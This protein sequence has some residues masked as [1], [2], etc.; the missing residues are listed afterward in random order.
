MADILILGGTRNLGHVTA[1]A[2][3]EAGHKV[4]VMN[5]GVTPDELPPDV[6]RLRGDRADSNQ[7]RRAIN[8]LDFDLVLDTTTYTG[9]DA[10]SAI[11]V[12]QGH[13]GRYV[14]VSTGQVYLV[15][16][17]ISRPFREESYDGP[18]IPEPPRE[19]EDY[20][21]WSYGAWK[22]DAED[23]FA[24]AFARY[25]FPVTT[26]RLPMVA[27]ERDHYGRIQ[28][29]VARLLDGNAI[30]VPDEP[31]LPLRHV[32]VG[33]VAGLVVQFVG[34]RDGMGRAYNIS[35]GESISLDDFLTLLAA[36]VD[37]PLQLERLPRAD[38]TEAGL[39][40]H[41]SPFSG[42]WMSE[43]DNTRSL[44]ELGLGISYSGPAIYLPPIISDFEKRWQ[45]ANIVPT[46]YK[47]RAR[48]KEFID[49]DAR[50]APAPHT[51]HR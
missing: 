6:H 20:D 4:S 12:F 3:L 31:G 35:Y 44:G 51:R 40:P 43:L 7:M 48:E 26:I 14:F 8:G 47:Q 24:A 2:L 11:D 33:D 36:I 49:R 18:L 10:R 17:G 45:S 15:R 25:G 16:E 22:R 50:R 41:C 13:V 32:Y 38:L 19:S 39:L 28:A 9:A 30:L 34:S 46:G 5:R 27:S 37:R 23:E 21:S 42:R 1:V 29:Y